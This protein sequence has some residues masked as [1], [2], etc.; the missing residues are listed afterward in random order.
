MR[1]VNIML[2][3]GRGG[4]EAMALRYHQ[5][6]RRA[7]FD[8]A[9]LGHARGV[10]AEAVAAGGMAPEDFVPV[11]ALINHDPRA[12]LRLHAVNKRFRP[13]VVLAHGNR[14][15]GI[16]L[17]PFAGTAGKTVQVVHNFRSKP[18]VERLRAAISVSASVSGHLRAAHPGL[19]VFEVL[20]FAPL[21]VHPVKAKPRGPPVI[22]ALGRLHKNKGIDILLRA[23][24]RL[25]GEARL[26]IA[27]DGPERTRL[28]ALA[29]ALGLGGRVEF[30]GWVSPAADYLATLDLFVVP[31]RVEPFGLVVAEGM[32][33]GVPVIASRIDGP[34]EILRD[35]ELG[36][37]VA[38]EDEAALAEAMA[39]SIGDWD[40]T[41][42]RAAAAQAYACEHFSL[43]AGARRLKAALE[44]IVPILG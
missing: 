21:D 34:R 18:Q 7:G 2:A 20:N 31:S 33:A 15:T 9:S 19:A 37:L 5:A 6:M 25:G 30:V 14:P 28:E 27:G 11:D 40:A 41:L 4:V 23:F 10:F 24:A 22:G 32:A 35:G 17:L 44:Q 3:E 16:A 39:L 12:A 13:D 29:A 26:T 38:P 1:I 43:E 42:R 8:V 36:R